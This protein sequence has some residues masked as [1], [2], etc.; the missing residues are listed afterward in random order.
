MNMGCLFIYLCLLS[1]LS[2]M[3]YS[4]HCKVFHLTVKFNL[5]YFLSFFLFAIVNTIV[6]LISFS[7]CSLLIYK[8]AIDFCML[9]L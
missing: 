3:F 7:D 8:N 2:A 5:N 6:L 4:F 9:I 1:F